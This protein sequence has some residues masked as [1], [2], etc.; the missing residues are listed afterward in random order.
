MIQV[1]YNLGPVALVAAFAKN[2]DIGGVTGNDSDVF[3]TRLLTAF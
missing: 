1:G 3:M 2:E